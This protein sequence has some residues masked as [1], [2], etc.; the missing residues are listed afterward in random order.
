M[1][2]ADTL[3]AQD[4]RIV[5]KTEIRG[6]VGVAGTDTQ[7]TD[8]HVHR[9]HLAGMASE[10]APAH[11]QGQEHIPQDREGYTQNHPSSPPTRCTVMGTPRRTIPEHA[12]TYTQNRDMSGTQTHKNVHNTPVQRADRYAR[13]HRTNTHPH[14]THQAGP[15]HHGAGGGRA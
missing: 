7:N 5:V 8:R 14:E 15:Q 2:N 10:R 6:G 3:L 1:Q 12:W 11:P 13:I 4:E 9:L